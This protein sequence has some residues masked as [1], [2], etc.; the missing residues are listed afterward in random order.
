MEERDAEGRGGSQPLA[1]RHSRSMPS[2]PAA[3]AL[4]DL[5]SPRDLVE[6]SA[7]LRSHELAEEAA[8]SGHGGH[9]GHHRQGG[10][11]S[12]D[13]GALEHRRQSW[14][15]QHHL[16]GRFVAPRQMRSSLLPV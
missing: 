1:M 2:F 6:L 8:K 15:E 11:A 4:L 5:T 10:G 12:G 3:S 9:G 7:R 16:S 14:I 13:G